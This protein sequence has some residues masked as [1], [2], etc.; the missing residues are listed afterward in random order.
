MPRAGPRRFGS[1]RAAAAPLTAQTKRRKRRQDPRRRGGGPRVGSVERLGSI[2]IHLVT[3]AALGTAVEAAGRGWG[4]RATHC[5]DGEGVA[6]TQR[7]AAPRRSR[8]WSRPVIRDRG[9]A[10]G[11]HAPRVIMGCPGSPGQALDGW[12]GHVRSRPVTSGHIRSRP[13]TS[14]HVRSR[15]VTSGRVR[16]PAGTVGRALKPSSRAGSVRGC[17][18]AES[19]GFEARNV[20]CWTRFDS[21]PKMDGEVGWG[22][23]STI[24]TPVLRS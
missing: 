5:D 20:A 2:L 16:G 1:R 11:G 24:S 19:G 8:C 6:P 4:R 17:G 22:G 23:F 18:P 9:E 7:A 12:H 21:C 13:V 15:P 10:E 3:R 14:G